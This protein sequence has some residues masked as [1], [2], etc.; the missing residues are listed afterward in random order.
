M[1]VDGESFNT[2][3]SLTPG[4]DTFFQP[5]HPFLCFFVVARRGKRMDCKDWSSIMLD[6]I[7]FRK[8]NMVSLTLAIV[9]GNGPTVSHQEFQHFAYWILEI[10]Q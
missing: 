5:L 9:E 4:V 1:R 7:S 10:K 2:L 8:G 6:T 3:P